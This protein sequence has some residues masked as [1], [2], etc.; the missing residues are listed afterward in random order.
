MRG[1]VVLIIADDPIARDVYCELFAMR[2]HRVEAAS[3]ARAGLMRVA[4]RPD[5]A[6]V[7]LALNALQSYAALRRR[8]HALAPRMRVHALGTMPS[9]YDMAMPARQQLH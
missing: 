2:G 3:G 1:S 7:V 4:R 6:V 5:V 8:L 9:F